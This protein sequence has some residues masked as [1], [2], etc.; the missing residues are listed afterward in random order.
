MD[1]LP[2]RTSRLARRTRRTTR[3]RVIVNATQARYL[4]GQLSSSKHDLNDED[5]ASLVALR[6]F[7]DAAAARERRAGQPVGLAFTRQDPQRGLV[8]RSGLAR[9]HKAG[10]SKSESAASA[11]GSDSSSGRSG[12]TRTSDDEPS[13]PLTAERRREIKLRISEAA[14]RRAAAADRRDWTVGWRVPSL[15]ARVRA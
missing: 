6:N 11:S 4:A 13:P 10:P 3:N 14:A 2:A 8:A 12:R 5:A 1:L 15:P 9:E 7:L